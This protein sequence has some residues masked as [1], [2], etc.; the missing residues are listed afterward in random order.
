MFNEESLYKDI[1]K[2]WGEHGAH[3]EVCR[4]LMKKEKFTSTNSKSMPCCKDTYNFVNIFGGWE[5]CPI[6]GNKLQ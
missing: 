3:A 6:C 1:V 4:E 5:Y 2:T